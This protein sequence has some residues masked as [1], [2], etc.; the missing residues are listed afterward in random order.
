MRTTVIVSLICITQALAADLYSQNTRLSLNMTNTTIKNVLNVIENQTDFYFIYEA[1]SVDVNRK[2]TVSAEDETVPQILDDLFTNTDITYKINDRRIALT[3]TTLT[4]TAQQQ[5]SVSG[6]VTDSSGTALS[7]VTVAVKGTTQGTI[8]DAEGNYS[9]TNVPANAVLV[10]SF[11]GM[12]TQEI[13]AGGKTDHQCYFR[14]G[15]D[16]NR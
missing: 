2:V 4:G 12:K 15:N 8:T 6:K 14:R 16:R 10:F 3:R 11:V 1:H 13:D 7:S 9:L 5:K